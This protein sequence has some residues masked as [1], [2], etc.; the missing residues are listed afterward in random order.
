MDASLCN[1]LRRVAVV[2]LIFGYQTTSPNIPRNHK[3]HGSIVHI[4]SC[5]ILLRAIWC[6]ACL[7]WYN[8]KF[9]SVEFHARLSRTKTTFII[10]LIAYSNS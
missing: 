10:S 3:K 4:Q 8:I 6:S 9:K 7:H 1:L 5:Q 2:L